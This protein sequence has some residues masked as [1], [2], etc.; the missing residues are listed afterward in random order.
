MEIDKRIVAG[1]FNCLNNFDCL[2]NDKHVY[3]KVESCINHKIHFIENIDKSLCNYKMS[4]GDS[5]ICTCPTRKEIFN[6]Y[7]Q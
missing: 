3:C 6:Q 1:T 2:N 4:F 7:R 5:F